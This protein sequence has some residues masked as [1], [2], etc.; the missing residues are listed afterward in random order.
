MNPNE[1]KRLSLRL[2]SC[3]EV[4]IIGHPFRI[5]S[6]ADIEIKDELIHWMVEKCAK[7]NVALEINS[8]YK[9]PDADLKMAALAMRRDVLLVKGSD[10]HFMKEFGDFTYHDKILEQALDY[11]KTQAVR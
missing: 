4:D 11:N 10:A 9:F 1:F 5:L 8:H 7:Y 2:I 6:R 3:G